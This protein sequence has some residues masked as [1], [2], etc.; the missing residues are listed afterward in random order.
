MR[1]LL[2]NDDGILAAGLAALR[3]AV[4]DLG[5]TVV[6]APDSPQS[7]SGRAIT[8]HEPI[9]CRQVQ[10]DGA[11]W[12]YGVAGRPADCVK[13]A[14]RQLM[15]APPDL[16]LAGINAGANV[17]VNVFY[18]GTV[19][20]AAEGALLGIPS[21]AFSLTRSPGEPM[22]V[23]RRA[24]RYCRWILQ[25]LLAGPLRASNLISVNI[26]QL[27]PSGPRGVKVVP[28]S[29]AAISESYQREDGSEGE[30]LFRLTEHYEHGPQEA[31]TDVTALADGF[32]TVTPLHSDLTD[33]PG[34]SDLAARQWG[35]LPP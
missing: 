22:A 31:E 20:A 11:F 1:I 16:V 10:V 17:G 9:R 19:Q 28:Q 3:Q 23:Y 15:P 18:S 32:I 27:D 14:V 12:G 26:P 35:N 8:L 2:V 4:E 21:V 25:G 33:R 5:E 24:A 7:A 13:L 29:T 30:M 6:V 34:L